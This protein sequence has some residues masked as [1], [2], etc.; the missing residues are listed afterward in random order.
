[1]ERKFELL[2]DTP[3]MEKGSI[4]TEEGDWWYKA[5]NSKD[6]RWSE[7]HKDVVENYHEWFRE[8]KPKQKRLKFKEIFRKVLYGHGFIGQ[9]DQIY[10][11]F[12]ERLKENG[13]EINEKEEIEK[14]EEIKSE[15]EDLAR[16]LKDAYDVGAECTA[17]ISF[18]KLGK[19]RQGY[20]AEADMVLQNYVKK[21]K[22]VEIAERAFGNYF[23][24][25]TDTT[26]VDY[27]KHELG[28]TDIP[29]V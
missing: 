17:K 16:E 19:Y 6:G 4:F 3:T 2:K 15:R 7:Y 13:H 9:L 23:A 8:I 24:G 21:T 18:K 12:V 1:M 10:K 11:D 25:H 28:L 20:L 5:K 14:P 27:L 29:D 22:V 26:I